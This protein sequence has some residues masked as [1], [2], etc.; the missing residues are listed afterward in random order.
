MTAVGESDSSL[1]IKCLDLCQTLVGQGLAFNFSLKIGSTF[2]FSLEARDKGLASDSPGK[3]KKKA[4]PSTLRR[5]ARRKEAFLKKRQNPVPD[6]VSTEGGVEP[7]VGLPKQGEDTFKCDIC[8]NGF[9]SEAG[10]KIHKGKTHKSQELPQIEMIKSPD[11]VQSKHVS[12]LKD[13]R[14]ELPNL[15]MFD[16]NVRGEKFETQDGQY[17]HTKTIQWCPRCQKLSCN[18]FNPSTT[19]CPGCSTPWASPFIESME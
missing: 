16:C 14:E 1:A 10:V 3:T 18:I 17:T 6:P 8:G 15:Q 7:E 11:N 19:P 2:S 5:N 13:V 12:P 9:K 4:S